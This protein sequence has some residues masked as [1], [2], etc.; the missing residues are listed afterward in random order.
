MEV[1]SGVV[2]NAR[3]WV[4]GGLIDACKNLLVKH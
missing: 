4:T 2:Q 1:V 3:K